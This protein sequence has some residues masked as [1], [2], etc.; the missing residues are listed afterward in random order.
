MQKHNTPQQLRTTL[1]F[2]V[3]AMPLQAL[4]E[5]EHQHD[6]G[7]PSVATRC[8]ECLSLHGSFSQ[9]QPADQMM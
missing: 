7:T 8:Q 3:Q 9:S 2:G 5:T 1:K 4:Q 6:P